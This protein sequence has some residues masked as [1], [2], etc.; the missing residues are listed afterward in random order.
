VF[1]NPNISNGD[2]NPPRIRLSASVHANCSVDSHAGFTRGGLAGQYAVSSSYESGRTALLDPRGPKTP[3]DAD[4]ALF[5]LS[6]GE[7]LL[8]PASMYMEVMP[9]V[10]NHQARRERIM[11][12]FWVDLGD[13]TPDEFE[14]GLHFPLFPNSTDLQAIGSGQEPDIIP[15]LVPP[16]QVGDFSS[17]PVRTRNHNLLRMHSPIQ[18]QSFVD[19]MLDEALDQ[20]MED[21]VRI[22]RLCGPKKCPPLLRM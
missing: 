11:I 15:G 21:V 8:F 7:I 12:E 22:P 1:N 6:P 4:G 20:P 5:G 19:T 13:I 14:A 18:L 2:S 17:L 10:M 9:T 16:I 3:F